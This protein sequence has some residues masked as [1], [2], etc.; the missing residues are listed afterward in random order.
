MNPWAALIIKDIGVGEGDGEVGVVDVRHVV[1]VVWATAAADAAELHDGILV[2]HTVDGQ[3]RVPA[4]GVVAQDICR[5]AGKIERV[6][7][8]H[9]AAC[10]WLQ[11]AYGGVVVVAGRIAT[12]SG[13]QDGKEER[14]PVA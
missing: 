1:V 12:G 14:Q 10:V 3:P 9:F 4:G 11:L 8:I 7:D 2:V 5:L 6:A 13:K